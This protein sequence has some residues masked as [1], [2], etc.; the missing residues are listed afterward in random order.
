MLAQAPTAFNADLAGVEQVITV[1]FSE[2]GRRAAEN[3][4]LGTDHGAGGPL[5]VIGSNVRGGLAGE[6][7]LMTPGALDGGNLTVQTDFRAVYST[8]LAEWFQTDPASILP[9]GP[10]PLSRN[11]DAPG[12]IR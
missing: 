12:L 7:A 3:A 5:M 1:V 11:D 4:S 9:G 6:P 10:F 2:F 8:I